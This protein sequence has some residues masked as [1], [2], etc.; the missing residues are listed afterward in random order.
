MYV[1]IDTVGNFFTER[2]NLHR[3]KCNFGK[4]LYEQQTQMT[5]SVISPIESEILIPRTRIHVINY[6]TVQLSG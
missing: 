5:A 3:K 2:L 6:Y 4:K 1:H